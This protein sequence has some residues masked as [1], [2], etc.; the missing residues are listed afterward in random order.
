MLGLVATVNTCTCKLLSLAVGL[1][2]QVMK[3]SLKIDDVMFIY[4]HVLLQYKHITNKSRWFIVIN[5]QQICYNLFGLFLKSF[6]S[7]NNI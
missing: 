6:V 7:T 1:L 3:H 5:W 4:L 2:C